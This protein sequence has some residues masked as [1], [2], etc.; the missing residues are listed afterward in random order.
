M[1]EIVHTY[2]PSNTDISKAIFVSGCFD[3]L[4]GL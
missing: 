2:E 4:W 3:I 1:Q